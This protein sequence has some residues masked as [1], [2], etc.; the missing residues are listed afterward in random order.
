M[1]S[2]YKKPILNGH[3]V[4][5]KGR[6]YWVFEVSK[7]FPFHGCEDI[8]KI[9]VYDGVYNNEIAW[10]HVDEKGE[11]IGGVPCGQHLLGVSGKNVR[12]LVDDVCKTLRF[13]E[14]FV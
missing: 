2:R 5:Y 11:Y 14:S 12:E 3:K 4:L 1:N 9:V 10:C 6:R 7:E 8:D 13:V